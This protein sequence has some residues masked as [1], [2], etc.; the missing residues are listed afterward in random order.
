MA[1]RPA[2]HERANDLRVEVIDELG[3]VLEEVYVT[4]INGSSGAVHKR[5]PTSETNRRAR[6]D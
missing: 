6:D 4:E 5:T 2:S 1:R 3:R